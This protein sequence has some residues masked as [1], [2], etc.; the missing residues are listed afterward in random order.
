MRENET[1]G[2]RGFGADDTLSQL[3]EMANRHRGA[4]A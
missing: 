2:L 3:N 1:L 4:K